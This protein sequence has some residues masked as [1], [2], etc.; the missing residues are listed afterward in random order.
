[1]HSLTFIGFVLIYVIWQNGLMVDGQKRIIGGRAVRSNRWPGY[2]R[3][4]H[5]KR[6]ICG[7]SLITSSFALTAGHC[8]FGNPPTSFYVHCNTKS[9]RRRGTVRR[10]SQIFIS[11]EYRD[12]TLNYDCAVI[13]LANVMPQYGT[14]AIPIY[15]YYLNMGALLTVYGH[16]ATKTNTNGP[17]LLH[18]VTVPS[19]SCGNYKGRS[20]ITNTMFCAGVLGKKDACFGDSGGPIV[21][22]NNLVGIVSWGLGCASDTHPGV[23][24]NCTALNIPFIQNILRQFG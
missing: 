23:Y 11:T 3:L 16:G 8:V 9:R 18:E 14:F 24:T 1:M 21:Y 4:H 17:T 19:I 20:A 12:N 7:A 2:C 5:G 6:F 13:K 22:Q 15:P 10:A